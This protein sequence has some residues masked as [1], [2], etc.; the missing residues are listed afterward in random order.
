M[1][2]FPVA[3]GVHLDYRKELT[4]D[5][6]IVVMPLP[7][8]LCVPLHQHVGTPAEPVVVS[9]QPV[10]KG[11]LLAAA[12]PG[13]VSAPIHSPTSG[14]IVDIVNYLA[15]HPSGLTQKTILLRTDGKDQWGE[16]PAPIADPF[17]A[18][19]REIAA[20]VAS[21]GIVGLGGAA[22][23]S[24]LKLNLR[25]GHTLDM[26]L[27]NGAECEPYLT[28][29]DRVMQ[30]CAAE[31]VNGARIM[32]HALSTSCIKLAIEENKPQAIKIM[33]EAGKPF[34]IQVIGVPVRYPM[35][36]AH[37]LVKAVTGRETP[38]HGRTASV[39][40]L[41][42]NVGTARA[43]DHAIRLGRPLISRVITVSGGAMNRGVNIDVPLGTLVSD[44]V[45]FCGGFKNGTMPYRIISGGPMMGH[46]LPGLDVPVVKGTCGILALTAEET[47][48]QP[49]GPCIRCGA[50]VTA[51]PSGLLPLSMAAYI[52]HED[53]AGAAR[54]GVE[55]CISCG[56]CS[57]I[58]PSHIPLMH[59]FE[60]ANGRLRALD[61]ERRK[62]EKIKTLT[63]ARQARLERIA[64]ARREPRHTVTP[65][66]VMVTPPATPPA[67]PPTGEIKASA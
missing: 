66:A 37:H 34:G 61:R 33:T 58:C 3:G 67:T 32:A 46:M 12:G 16:L 48:E 11:Q 44:L 54:E 52:I 14:H 65:S 29:D 43:V 60:Y 9:G 24:A 35:G 53:M 39:G 15:P 27:L 25:T 20:R 17:T 40:V 2:I 49:A 4:R 47:N 6:E 57:Y 38:A 45:A 31:V 64:A 51:C 28:C 22:F 50:C 19:P 10:K 8:M 23:P 59:Y 26:L 30:E 36:S 18:T 56:S 7:R 13:A 42:H 41:V 1:K 63:E 5:L 62:H 55:D 21:A